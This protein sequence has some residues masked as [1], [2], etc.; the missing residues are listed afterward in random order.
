[1]LNKSCDSCGSAINVANGYYCIVV[2]RET[3]VEPTGMRMS[4]NKD[5]CPNCY[6]TYTLK[7][8]I[9]RFN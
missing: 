9:E 7:Q 1:M 8:L 2:N 4:N 3:N 5:V 6:E